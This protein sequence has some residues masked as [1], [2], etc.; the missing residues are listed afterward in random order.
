[1]TEVVTKLDSGEKTSC[2][3]DVYNGNL[4][5]WTYLEIKLI[6]IDTYDVDST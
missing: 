1:M 3:V 6:E 4:T 2:F 5:L